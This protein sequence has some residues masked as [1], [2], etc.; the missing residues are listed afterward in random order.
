[1]KKRLFS[2]ALALL[3]LAALL[4]ARVVGADDAKTDGV[5]IFKK[6]NTAHGKSQIRGRL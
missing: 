1:M 6:C 4:P 2:A 3:M 5:A